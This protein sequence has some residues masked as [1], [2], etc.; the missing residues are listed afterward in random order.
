[1]WSDWVGVPVQPEG[2]GWGCGKEICGVSDVLP[3]QIGKT[4]SF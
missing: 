2:V 4:I 3:H 1:M